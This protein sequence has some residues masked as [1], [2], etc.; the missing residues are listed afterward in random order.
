MS[1]AKGEVCVDRARITVN[2][3]MTSSVTD[4]S[5]IQATTEELTYDVICHHARSHR[6]EL[7]RRLVAEEEARNELALDEMVGQVQL[8]GDDFESFADVV[9]ERV[10]PGG[11]VDWRRMVTLLA[12]ASRMARREGQEVEVTSHVTQ[13]VVTRLACWIV[14]QGTLV[15]WRVTLYY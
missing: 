3:A 6:W 10:F 15:S 8:R 11:E 1:I 13:F 14:R 9:V 2:G 4:D 7:V 5:H 12:L